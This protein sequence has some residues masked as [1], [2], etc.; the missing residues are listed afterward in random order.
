MLGSSGAIAFAVLIAACTSATGEVA[1]GEPKSSIGT[2]DAG[3]APDGAPD[4]ATGTVGVTASCVNGDEGGA[5]PTTPVELQA[6]LGKYGYRCWTHESVRHPSSG[7]HHGQVQT[8][9][10]A[11]LDTSLKGTSEHPEGSVAVK[12]FYADANATEPDGWAVLVKTQASS[13][14]GQGY[15]WYEAFGI[16][17]GASNL[18]GQGKTLC[19]NCHSAGTDYV[20]IPYPLR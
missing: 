19:V 14:N 5:V 18:E 13:A 1:G 20:R 16:G 17:P 6:W 11:K 8:Y 2:S 4:A 15:Y 9:L 12:E 3:G 7:P 10:N